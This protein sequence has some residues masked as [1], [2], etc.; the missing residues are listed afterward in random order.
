VNVSSR[1]LKTLTQSNSALIELQFNRSWCCRW[2]KSVIMQRHDSMI[3]FVVWQH[4]SSVFGT[5]SHSRVQPF[6]SNLGQDETRK[7]ETLPR[8]DIHVSRDF[9]TAK[10]RIA[11]AHSYLYAA[12]TC[13]DGQTQIID[14]NWSESRVSNR[15]S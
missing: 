2:T 10:H 4:N 9:I 1:S 15:F 7:F 3:M 14:I 11:I 13:S 6:S 5:Q 12:A 8:Q